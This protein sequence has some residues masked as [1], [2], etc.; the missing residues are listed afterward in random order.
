MQQDAGFLEQ[1]SRDWERG[2]SDFWKAT[3]SWKHL[4]SELVRIVGMNYEYLTLPDPEVPPPPS[5]D[6]L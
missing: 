4:R 5:P 6:T 3:E 2:Q 1:K